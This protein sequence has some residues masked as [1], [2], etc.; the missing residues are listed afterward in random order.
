MSGILKKYFATVYTICYLYFSKIRHPL[1]KLLKVLGKS[2]GLCKITK[3]MDVL[4]INLVSTVWRIICGNFN[5]N[6]F[7]L[8]E[9]LMKI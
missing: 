9:I 4:Y 2:V 6:G 5:P 8:A 7:M 3:R 1:S